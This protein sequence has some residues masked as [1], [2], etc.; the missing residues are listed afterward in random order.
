MALELF[1]AHLERGTIARQSKAIDDRFIDIAYRDTV[2]DPVG[3]VRRIYERFQLPFS[4]EHA[5]RIEHHVA[6]HP[7]D[8][9]GAHKYT[10]EEFGL[11]KATLKGLMPEYRARFADYLEEPVR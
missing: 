3:T 5:R 4:P 1:G 6:Q 10:P 2:L 7:Q 8:K 11:D 9:H